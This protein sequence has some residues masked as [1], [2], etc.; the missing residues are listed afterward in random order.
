M[1]KELIEALNALEK[2]KKINKETIFTA[3]I[4]N[5]RTGLFVSTLIIIVPFIVW[6]ILRLLFS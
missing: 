1:N 5:D 6:F 4:M 2:E 3:I